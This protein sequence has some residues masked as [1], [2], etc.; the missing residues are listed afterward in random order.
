LTFNRSAVAEV[1]K[2]TTT[3]MDDEIV[4]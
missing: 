2:K 1:T 4:E 3:V